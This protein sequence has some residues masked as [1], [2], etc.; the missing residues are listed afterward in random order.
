MIRGARTELLITAL[1]LIAM[2]HTIWRLQD[3]FHTVLPHR[4]FRSAQL[5]PAHLQAHVEL[6][7]IRTIIN[8]RGRNQDEAWYVNERAGA[9]TL[10]IEHIDLPIDS[11]LPTPDEMLLLASTLAKCRGPVLLHCQSGIDRTGIASALAL[12]ALDDAS[13]PEQALDQLSWRFGSLP[14][15]QSLARKKNFIAGYKTWLHHEGRTHSR[16]AFSDWLNQV[17]KMPE[18]WERE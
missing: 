17:T 13:T 3:N 12:L 5:S 10:G 9:Q 14:G 11:F 7:G 6:N 4:L 15:R 16:A 8:L 18:P 1:F 2:A